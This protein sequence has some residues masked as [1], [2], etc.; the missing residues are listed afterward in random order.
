MKWAPFNTLSLNNT[1]ADVAAAAMDLHRLFLPERSNAFL[2]LP[3]VRS[4]GS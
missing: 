4:S 2:M 1:L 3:M